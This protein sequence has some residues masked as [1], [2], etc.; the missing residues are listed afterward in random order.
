MSDETIPVWQH[1]GIVQVIRQDGEYVHG[2][3][4]QVA[5]DEVEIVDGEISHLAEK[6]RGCPI[7]D[8]NVRLENMGGR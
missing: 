6:D 1:H 8:A 4:C 7:G 5:D 3:T 2:C